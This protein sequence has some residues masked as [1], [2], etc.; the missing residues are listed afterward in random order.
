[1]ITIQIFSPIPSSLPEGSF[2]SPLLFLGNSLWHS[3]PFPA[4]QHQFQLS[5][6]LYRK[7]EYSRVGCSVFLGHGVLAEGVAGG[8][9]VQVVQVQGFNLQ[10]QW[11]VTVFNTGTFR[12]LASQLPSK[13][14]S[15]L[16]QRFRI[17]NP[18]ERATNVSFFGGRSDL[19]RLLSTSVYTL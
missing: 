8:G 1:M 13:R 9:Q 17:C 5:S 14:P 2:P 3:F 15:H 6:E 11:G 10:Q 7:K 16:Q 19:C 4:K 12:S 18:F